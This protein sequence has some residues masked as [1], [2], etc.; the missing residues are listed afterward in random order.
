MMHKERRVA[1]GGVYPF[2]WTTVYDNGAP[3]TNG[4]GGDI[5]VQPDYESID[6]VNGGGYNPCDHLVWTAVHNTGQI[7]YRSS[8]SSTSYVSP[9]LGIEHWIL[10]QL[11]AVSP[12]G[13]CSAVNLDTLSAEAFSSMRP[14]M[15]TGF[16]LTN[17]LFELRDV[18]KMFSLVNRHFG[19]GKNIAS[20]YL[21]L[22]FGWLPFARDLKR[23]IKGINEFE[24]RFV[25]FHQRASV[26]QRKHFRRVF[27]EPESVVT[28]VPGQFQKKTP[29]RSTTYTATLRYRYMLPEMMTEGEMYYRALLD[30]L[31]LN[32]SPDKI[33]AAIPFSFL[34]D[35]VVNVEQFLKRSEDDY[36]RPK[37]EIIAFQY[38]LKTETREIYSACMYPQY[39]NPFVVLEDHTFRQYTR[40]GCHIPAMNLSLDP[41]DDWNVYRVSLGAALLGSNFNTKR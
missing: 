32:L 4:S 23:Y 10:G 19:I 38:S 20:Q 29:A 31:G 6:Y 2:H 14:T 40:S 35:W 1:G 13:H 27:E 25:E 24:Q 33:W 28:M 9:A 22:N 15:S 30:T 34:G 3:S 26:P 41:L 21:N 37:L 39:G 12:P 5:T 17:F 18:K 36:L 8:A 11:L 16:S 7:A